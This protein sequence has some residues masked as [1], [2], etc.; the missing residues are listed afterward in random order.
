M[1]NYCCVLIICII[2]C[3][4]RKLILQWTLHSKLPLRTARGQVAPWHMWLSHN[5]CFKSKCVM[6]QDHWRSLLPWFAYSRIPVFK[7]WILNNSYIYNETEVIRII[8]PTPLS[9][10]LFGWALQKSDWDSA[11]SNSH[12]WQSLIRWLSCWFWI[13]TSIESIWVWAILYWFYNFTLR[14]QSYIYYFLA[15]Y[16]YKPPMDTIEKVTK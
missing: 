14:G 4:K 3:F 12:S 5:D 10:M 7:L 16:Y 8:W 9:W 15:I 13:F 6:I 2:S 1:H 11:F